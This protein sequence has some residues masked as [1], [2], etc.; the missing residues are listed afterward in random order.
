MVTGLWRN[1]V[2]REAEKNRGVGRYKETGVLI[3][4]YDGA[5]TRRKEDDINVRDLTPLD[6]ARVGKTWWEKS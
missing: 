5:V 4:I 3:Y 6:G 1:V 2:G